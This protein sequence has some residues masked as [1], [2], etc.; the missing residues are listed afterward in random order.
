MPLYLTSYLG[1][2][3]EANGPFPTYLPADTTHLIC[4]RNETHKIQSSHVSDL[5]LE[6]IKGIPND[7]LIMYPT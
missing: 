3:A 2:L 6:E 1:P 5:A 7:Q 4:T